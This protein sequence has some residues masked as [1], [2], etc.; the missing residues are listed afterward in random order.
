MLFRNSIS[1]FATEN[2][3]LRNENNGLTTQNDE[4]EY[5]SEEGSGFLPECDVAG[6]TLKFVFLIPYV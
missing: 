4:F 5:V 2:V 3:D 1:I 6:K